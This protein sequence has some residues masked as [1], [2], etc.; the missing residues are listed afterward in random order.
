MFTG[1]V[2]SCTKVLERTEKKL[3]IARPQIFENLKIGQSIAT[4]GA[5]LSVASF[6]KT[7]ISFDVLSETYRRT[8]LADVSRLNLERAMRADGR[9]EGHIVLGHVDGMVQ[10]LSREDE[11]SGTK[12]MLSLP[13][14]KKLLVEKGSITL[15][16]VSLT[17]GKIFDESFEI[18]LIPLTL[19][20]TNLGDIQVGDALTFE[21]DYIAKIISKNQ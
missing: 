3:V 16:G 10:V 21:Y 5:C 13:R 18:Y 19:T 6:D 15:N 4:N 20:D 9:F 12:M 11:V 2:E 17:L 7:S 14:E 1:I 8:N